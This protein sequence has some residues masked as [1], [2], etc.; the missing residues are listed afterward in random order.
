MANF[1]HLAE[2]DNAC[3]RCGGTLLI[4]RSMQDAVDSCV[5]WFECN[6]CG[7]DPG[8]DKVETVWGFQEEYIGRAFDVWVEGLKRRSNAKA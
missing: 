7:F 6:K 5:M 4:G 3:P 1:L 2:G 8:G